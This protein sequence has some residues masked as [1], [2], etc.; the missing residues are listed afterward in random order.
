MKKYS[1]KKLAKLAG[2]TVRTLHHYDKIDLLKPALRSDKHYRY[3]GQ[4]ELL[5]LQQI[6]FYKELGFPLQ[7]IK[8][9]L[10][11]PDFDLIEALESHKKAL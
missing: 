8:E 6:L 4:E 7:E 2:V 9:I 10:E 5:R 3:Y 11:D 1:V